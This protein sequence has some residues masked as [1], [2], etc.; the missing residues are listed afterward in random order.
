MRL[1][2]PPVPGSV[3]A[4]LK[5][6]GMSAYF[7][8]AKPF[9]SSQS[10]TNCPAGPSLPVGLSMF[11]SASARSTTSLGSIF[12][13]TSSTATARSGP[14]PLR[15]VGIDGSRGHRRH[16]RGAPVDARGNAEALRERGGH[17]DRRRK[18]D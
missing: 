11:P 12:A 2:P 3:A 5:R 4:T 17:E 10:Y 16:G 9:L 1:Y 6:S 18:D 15:S 13:S 8:G 7:F 14:G